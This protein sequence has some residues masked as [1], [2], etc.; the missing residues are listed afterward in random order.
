MT[1]H[2]F[3][4]QRPK[5]LAQLPYPIYFVCKHPERWSDLIES[6]QLPSDV[7]PLYERCLTV[8]DIWTAQPYI[9]LKQAGLN[10]FLVPDYVPG[11]I[12]LI[13]WDD[14]RTG[15]RPYNSYVVA[16]QCDRARP[17]VCEQRLVINQLN[18]LTKTDHY[19]PHWPQPNLIP[20]SPDRGTQVKNLAFKGMERNI[21][22]PFRTPEFKAQLQ[23]L[24]I[25]FVVTPDR[26]D[27]QPTQQFREWAD[28]SQAD[29]VIAVRNNTAYDLTVKPALKLIN[30]WLAGCPAILGPEPAYQSLRQSELDFIEVRSV[31]QTIEA[32]E[33]LKNDPALYTAMVEN[34]WQRVKE[35]TTEQVALR[36]RD[37]LAAPIAH[38]YEQ[39][40]QQS[41]LQKKLGRPLQFLVRRYQHKRAQDYHTHNMLNGAR[42]FGPE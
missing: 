1:T 4:S 24:G 29:V 9:T 28:Y 6:Q 30:A 36:W 3:S 17:Y 8:S 25:E 16:C 35:F 27:D 33:R 7:T 37:V 34:G 42:L 39:W 40:K 26:I 23:A 5:T 41:P 32:L 22:H 11:E 31:K 12:C 18:V 14:L 15:D 21:A 20:R 19:L 2:Y 13:P 10:V 38:G